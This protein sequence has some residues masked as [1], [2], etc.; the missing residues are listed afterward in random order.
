LARVVKLRKALDT[1]RKRIIKGWPQ[2]F[3]VYVGQNEG[4]GEKGKG[5]GVKKL[6]G[7]GNR[8]R[9]EKIFK[10]KKGGTSYKKPPSW[11]RT[12]TKGRGKKTKS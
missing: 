4:R 2:C 12:G 6:K 10:G 8:G 11:Y 3:S 7:K 9:T 5:N 1:D